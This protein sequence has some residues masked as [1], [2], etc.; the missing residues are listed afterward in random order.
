M[1]AG[2]AM[3]NSM[4]AKI[5]DGRIVRA[6]RIAELATKIASL[7]QTPRLIII[8]VGDRADSTAFINAKKALAK[9]LG[10]VE[11]HLQLPP[12]ISES[13]VIEQIRMFNDDPKVTGI[14]VQLPLPAQINGD[15]V[16]AAID[17][18]KDVDGL[19]PENI[20][21][22]SADEQTILPAT[23][24]GI[25]ELLDYYR[26]S[27]KDKQITVVG[28]SKLVGSP[29]ASMCR[30]EGAT[31]TTC[32][33]STADLVSE[34]KKADVLIVAAGKPG[35]ITAEHVKPGQIVIDVG[36]TR[37]PQGR[38]VGD[39]DYESVKEI[40]AAITPVPG[41]VGQMTV[42]ALFENL[43]DLCK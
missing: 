40:V 20:A 35:L 23:A 34:T 17:P 30:A 9:E 32:D 41:G 1:K 27:L 21:A 43:I 12:T 28:K 8:Q 18:K 11:I 31:V 15:A 13:E 22:L 16:I 6:A 25:K 38:L 39:V 2:Y 37:T 33:R 19:V 24:R 7:S 4:L 10:V 26:I 5:L 3:L 42:L 29:I 14:I 36:I